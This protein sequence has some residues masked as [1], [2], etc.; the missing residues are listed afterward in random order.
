MVV[1]CIWSAAGLIDL[2]EEG[3]PWWYLII[4]GPCAWAIWIVISIIAVIAWIVKTFNTGYDRVSEWL[5][6]KGW[7]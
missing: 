3:Q 2:F 1:I 7:I 6:E 4:R 5:I